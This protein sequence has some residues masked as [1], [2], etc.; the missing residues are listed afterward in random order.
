MRRP[1][2]TETFSEL[3]CQ[4]KIMQSSIAE[5]FNNR[6]MLTLY[7]YK[8]LSFTQGET[9]HEQASLRDVLIFATGSD[10]IPPT[11]FEPRPRIEFLY[12]TKPRANTCGNVLH[13]PLHPQKRGGI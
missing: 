7:I 11:G 12:N 2:T 1:P 13:L 10:E 9:A 4:K 3:I 5:R 6:K 8:H